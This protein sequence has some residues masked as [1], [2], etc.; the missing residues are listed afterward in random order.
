MVTVEGF[1]CV[2]YGVFSVGVWWGGC[3]KNEG[4]CLEY[5]GGYVGVVWSMMAGVRG[6]WRTV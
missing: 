5:D 6:V 1:W 2:R 3:E 4:R